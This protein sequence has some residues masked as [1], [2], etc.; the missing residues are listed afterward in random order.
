MDRNTAIDRLKAHEAQLRAM[1]VVSL[2]LFGSTARGEQRP[3]SDV[4]VAAKLVDDG[5]IGLFEVAAIGEAVREA[6]G[7][8]VD[9]VTEP[10]RK[11]RLQ[12][13]IDRDRVCVF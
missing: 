8:A 2:S 12:H 9:M 3:D 11:A 5:R 6:L 10:A 7:V 13:E 1:G 4:D